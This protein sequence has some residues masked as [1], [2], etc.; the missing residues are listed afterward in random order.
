MNFLLQR[1]E[2]VTSKNKYH[3]GCTQFKKRLIKMD[4]VYYGNEGCDHIFLRQ[5]RLN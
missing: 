3:E 2:T 4:K 5:K 1:W